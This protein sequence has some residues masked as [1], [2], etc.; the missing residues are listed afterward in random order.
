MPSLSATRVE[1]ETRI[2]RSGAGVVAAA[3]DVG[4]AVAVADPAVGRGTGVDAA[5]VDAGADVK[6]SNARVGADVDATCVEAAIADMDACIGVLGTAA[7]V[8]VD[9]GDV[10][11]GVRV[12]TNATAGTVG[13]EV[14]LSATGPVAV[15]V[16]GASAL[17]MLDPNTMPTSRSPTAKAAQANGGIRP[18]TVSTQGRFNS[19][20]AV[21]AVR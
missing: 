12:S 10:E 14:G 13:A 18:F 15:G 20:V 2:R 21:G 8:T 19:G 6:V 11:V 9:D 16:A 5:V 3:V 4:V 1:P 7:G 17:I